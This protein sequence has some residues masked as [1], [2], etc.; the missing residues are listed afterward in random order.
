MTTL[1]LMHAFPL[2]A[3]MYGGVASAFE[4]EMLAP[5]L[6]GFG[7]EALAEGEPSLDAY[8]R[9]VGRYL[10]ERGIERAVI[11]G[12]SMGGYTAMAFYRL[13]PER[14]AGLALIDTKATADARRGRRGTPSDGRRLMV[15]ERSRRPHWSRTCCPSCLGATTVATRPDV[16][17][18][19]AD[20]VRSADPDAAAWAQRAMAARPDSLEHA[21]EVDVPSLVVVGGRTFS[22]RRA[23]A[24]AMA[25]ALPAASWC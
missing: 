9:D 5:D 2:D 23:D 11:G 4:G 25:T 8:A 10:D 6:P 17:A 21:R 3:T 13:F 16:V 20:W 7:G 22:R 15:D 12:T 18:T 19:V 1:V 24:A 14:V